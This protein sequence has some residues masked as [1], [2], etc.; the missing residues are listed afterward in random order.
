[1]SEIKL[2]IKNSI[3]LYDDALFGKEEFKQ[4]LFSPFY[5]REKGWCEPTAGGRGASWF[6][7][8]DK[9]SWVLRHYRRGG[10][11][12]KF[13]DDWYLWTGEKSARPLAEWDV[14]QYLRERDMPVPQAVALRI[15]RST[16]GYRGDIITQR[17]P[18]IPLSELLIQG[19]L[20]G[21]VWAAVGVAA[22][23]LHRAGVWHADLNA[24]NILVDDN[25]AYLLDF[26]RAQIKVP[27][28]RWRKNNITRLQRSLAKL[29]GRE[30]GDT[31]HYQGW[32]HALDCYT[33]K[34]FS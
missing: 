24:H 12:G 23:R 30:I 22:A 8:N 9:R 13:I 1:M 3:I 2:K 31:E 4:T 11:V 7:G 21:E 33:E 15:T 5:W 29:L 25:K 28:E 19:S 26:D 10:L 6:I 17:L 18:G 16:F 27:A 32:R 14:L 34:Y 20:N